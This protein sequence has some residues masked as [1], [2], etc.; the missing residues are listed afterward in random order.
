MFLSSMDEH[1]GELDDEDIVI[2]PCEDDNIM[3]YISILDPKVFKS[4]FT[5]WA[6]KGQF[7]YKDGRVSYGTDR[8]KVGGG[9]SGGVH[10]VDA[11][12]GG[13]SF[14]IQFGEGGFKVKTPWS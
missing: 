2:D 6:R 5:E 10:S 1:K 4:K 12:I 14:G 7:D 11:S 3:D 9:S 8:V 13:K